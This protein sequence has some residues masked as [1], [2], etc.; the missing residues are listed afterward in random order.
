MRRG[1]PST[2]MSNPNLSR[3][4]SKRV[5]LLCAVASLF[6][7]LTNPSRA[8][9]PTAKGRLSGSVTSKSTGSALQGAV[10][11]VPALNRSA[12]TDNTGRYI[13]YDLPS[14]AVEVVVSYAGFL[15]QTQP[16]VVQAGATVELP[17]DMANSD[18]VA[19]EK[20]TVSAVKE[21]QSLALT[22][23]RNAPNV[24]TVAALDEWGILPTQNVGELASRLPGVSF[25]VDTDDNVINGVSIRG[26]P[27][28]FTRLNID[29][30]AST[31]VGGDGRNATLYSFSGAQYEQI[32]IIAGQTPDKRADSLGGQLNLVTRSPLAMKEKR[33]INYNISARWAP[34]F[35]DRT[36]LRA[37]HAMHPTASLS[38]AEVFSIF[39]GKRNLG[40]S[41]VASYTENVNPQASNTLLY[42][43]AVDA[44]VPFVDYADFYGINHRGV[45]GLSFK[46]DYRY[47][48][49]G[50]LSFNVLYNE[51]AEPF[52]RRTTITPFA[53]N[54]TT[55]TLDVN[56][57]PTGTGAIL[58][59]FTA[60]TTDIRA[61]AG[62]TMRLGTD[63]F[64]FYSQNPTFTLSGKNEF[65][66]LKLSYGARYSYTHFDSGTGP[67]N[68]GGTLNIRTTLPIGFTLDNSNLDGKVFTQTAGPN[69]FDPLTFR[70]PGP[71]TSTNWAFT[72]R[73]TLA[74]TTEKTVR[75]DA[76]YSFNT[77]I[78]ISIKSGFDYS[79]RFV[80]QGKGKDRQWRRVVG[81]PAITGTLVPITRFEQVNLGGQRL[82]VF[83]PTSVSPELSNPALWTEDVAFAAARPFVFRR[84]LRE[85]VPAGYIQSQ[86]RI[87]RLTVLAGVRVEKVEAETLNYF[88]RITPESLLELD[89]FKK[90]VLEFQDVT[91]K[92]AYTKAFPSIHFA[93]DITANLKARASWST[94]YGRPTIQQLAPTPTV[95]ETTRT[96]TAGN[97]GLRPQ[98]G[99]NIDL[100]L[101]Y[102]F[103]A[104][105][106]VSLGY[107]KKTITDFLSPTGS[108][109]GQV[110]DGADNGFDGLFGGFDVFASTNLGTATAEGL[111]FDYRQ[112]LTFLPGLLKGLTL[113]ANY[114]VLRTNGNFGGTVARKSNDVPGFIPRTGNV[115]VL[116][117][118]K[119]F[120][121]SVDVNY[122]SQHIAPGGFA[123]IGSP[124][125]FYREDLFAVN[126]GVTFKLR[127]DV[128]FYANI[129]NILE[130]ETKSFR[131]IETRPRS[132]NNGALTMSVGVTGQF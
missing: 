100:K 119:K 105:G 111:E 127:P 27:A 109:I 24:K 30:M 121:A 92:G 118:Y 31:G 17:F 75:F 78:P 46:A 126:T 129:S 80:D 64:S 5:I 131:F 115:R 47:A 55:A 16:A 21:G 73:K 98:L 44:V 2:P 71:A 12:L 93:Y 70:P 11:V 96:V 88:R 51:G 41:V 6:V 125:N 8:A 84:Q 113:S 108:L 85:K 95:N 58:P 104:N 72:R 40:I 63:A 53:G 28:N 82:P 89:P 37:A 107:F 87:S 29:G 117:A 57:L 48:D 36:A 52:Y 81:A 35:S 120:G 74:D 103:K 39:G 76:T 49:N 65:G 60:N 20:F 56:G 18:V 22:E 112:R 62:S 38:Y 9:E 132:V 7:I 86:A 122:T 15:E 77:S 97:A 106:A 45:A 110:A 10:V 33:R 43:N 3:L 116:Y 130:A 128:T 25:A 91:R 123:A 99:E 50:Y 94:S 59:G 102:Y 13:F 114:T 101:E 54:T 32:E 42:R 14:G 4:L 26:Q 19:L 79:N 69:L 61:V 34:P 67:E 23:Q 90:A 66:R 68:Q 1:Q 83:D 124:I